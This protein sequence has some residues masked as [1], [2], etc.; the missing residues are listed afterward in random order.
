[1][2]TVVGWE[3]TAAMRVTS[4]NYGRATGSCLGLVTSPLAR[5]SQPGCWCGRQNDCGDDWLADWVWCCYSANYDGCRDDWSIGSAS[6]WV[7]PRVGL[8]TSASA[9]VRVGRVYCCGVNLDESIRSNLSPLLGGLVS[10]FNY[11]SGAL[12]KTV[13]KS[14]SHMAVRGG[15][16]WPTFDFFDTLY[17]SGMATASV[18]RVQCMQRIRCSLCQIALASCYSLSFDCVDVICIDLAHSS[19]FS[20]H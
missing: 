9:R 5:V 1:M 19:Q 7:S 8:V 16:T 4:T 18:L 14:V 12:T 17:I 15:V 13:Q 2:L 6:S 10:A 3:T 11:Y 20:W